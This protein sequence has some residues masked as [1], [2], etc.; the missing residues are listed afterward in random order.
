MG[1]FFNAKICRMDDRYFIKEI[2]TMHLLLN[3]TF[4]HEIKDTKQQA[5]M[6]QL[7]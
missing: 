1:L 4:Y 2:K 3:Q 5:V 6:M 7:V